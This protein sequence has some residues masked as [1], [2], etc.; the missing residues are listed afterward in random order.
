MYNKS[1]VLTLHKIFTQCKLFNRKLSDY[2]NKK[3]IQSAKQVSSKI[4][5]EGVLCS[6]NNLKSKEN[7]DRKKAYLLF[8]ITS[9]FFCSGL[10]SIYIYKQSEFRNILFITIIKRTIK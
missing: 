1:F 5:M 3:K 9:Q 8:S 10:R 4:V 7:E 6:S 2:R